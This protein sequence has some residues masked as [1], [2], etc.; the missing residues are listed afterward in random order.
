MKRRRKRGTTAM[1]RAKWWCGCGST[2]MPPGGKDNFAGVEALT[3]VF[4]FMRT[5]RGTE[6]VRQVRE[7]APEESMEG[8]WA[9][10][11]VTLLRS[12][13]WHIDRG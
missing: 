5:T 8:V 2:V 12:G 7:G 13:G 11:V 1:T 3:R 10:V 6:L 4:T 9:A